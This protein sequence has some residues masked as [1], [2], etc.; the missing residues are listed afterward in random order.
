MRNTKLLF[1]M[2]LGFGLILCPRFIDA[3]TEAEAWDVIF[4]EVPFV[5]E[6]DG[7]FLDVDS[8]PYSVLE[9]NACSFTYDEYVSRHPYSD[10]YTEEKL[11]E[12]YNIDINYCK[13]SL[14]YHAFSHISDNVSFL[15]SE[16]G[17]EITATVSHDE[18]TVSKTCTLRYSEYDEDV[19]DTSKE[20]DKKLDYVYTLYGYDVINS[21]Y[22]YGSL[23][24]DVW[25]S[26]YVMYRFPKIKE[27]LM[28]YPEFGYDTS[29]EA[30]SGSFHHSSGGFIKFIKNDIL[31][32]VH[33]YSANYYGMLLVDENEEGTTLDKAQRALENHFGENVDFRFDDEVWDIDDS[34]FD[35]ANKAFGTT[36]I[37]YEGIDVMLFI[38]DTQFNIGVVEMDKKAIKDFEV[39]AK[40]KGTG[41][42]VYTNSYDVPVD[43]T[44]EVEDVTKDMDKVFDKKMYKVYGAYDIDV[45]KMRDGGF[46]KNIENGIDV[47]LPI[48]GKEVGDELSVRHITDNGKG[49]EF[50]GEVVEDDGKLYVKFTTTHFSTYAV[51]EELS[52]GGIGSITNPNTGDNLVLY[53]MLGLSGLGALLLGVR[54]FK[55]IM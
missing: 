55:S 45:V 27:V 29:S 46:V 42:H 4:E 2:L 36:G 17:K 25:N 37:D 38:G 31:Y 52:A 41:V 47:Y 49:E 26:N 54:K 11:Q 51:V 50:K 43:A 3:R 9:E 14:K 21:F 18:G 53:I 1:C 10:T 39:R 20:I 34:G 28:D 6:K 35:L 5:D 48:T 8:V 40:H 24:N 7:C 22:H 30:G 44:L 33:Y 23:S 32:G 13:S 16:D 15:V 12:D 19:L